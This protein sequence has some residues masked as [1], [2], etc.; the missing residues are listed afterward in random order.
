MKHEYVSQADMTHTQLRTNQKNE[1]PFFE[2]SK[3]AEMKETLSLMSYVNR[4]LRSPVL[5]C[6]KVI[7]KGNQTIKVTSQLTDG[8]QI[9]MRIIKDK[10]KG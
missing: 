7:R 6:D 9:K 4:P 5:Q 1:E 8:N 2:A 3:R 10:S